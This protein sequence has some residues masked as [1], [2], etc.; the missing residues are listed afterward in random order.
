MET[1]DFLSS[2]IMEESTAT[3]GVGALSAY[4]CALLGSVPMVAHPRKPTVMV[5]AIS[6]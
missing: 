5:T 3:M 2:L 6:A 1:V 4:C